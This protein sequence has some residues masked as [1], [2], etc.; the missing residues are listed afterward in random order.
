MYV[1][2]EAGLGSNRNCKDQPSFGKAIA[3]SAL[4]LGAG[5]ALAVGGKGMYGMAKNAYGGDIKKALGGGIAAA[6]D[7]AKKA[8]NK[9]KQYAGRSAADAVGG[10]NTVNP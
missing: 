4:T 6:K 1:G 9:G 10:A 3:K 5:A 7:V 2:V 8:V